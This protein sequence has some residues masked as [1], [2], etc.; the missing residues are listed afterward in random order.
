MKIALIASIT[1]LFAVLSSP[2]ASQGDG[3]SQTACEL[4]YSTCKQTVRADYQFCKTASEKNCRPKLNA[5]LN[6]CR[7]AQTRCQN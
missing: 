5:A 3:G 4:Q 2:A 6:N 7:A 1:V